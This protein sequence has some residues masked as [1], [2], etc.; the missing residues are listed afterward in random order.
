[1]R[2][3]DLPVIRVARPCREPWAEMAGDD[4]IRHC[5]RCDKDVHDLGAMTT[6]EILALFDRGT[7]WCGRLFR[8]ADGTVVTADCSEPP[9]RAAAAALGVGLALSTAA[10]GAICGTRHQ[11]YV[12]VAKPPVEAP[13]PPAAT[14][15]DEP[16]DDWM[17]GEIDPIE[18]ETMGVMISNEPPP[19][20]TPLQVEVVDPPDL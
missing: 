16:V 8:R 14:T 19:L 11:G 20:I 17:V 13:A 5:E 1:M 18:D 7:P 4:R 12:T 6:D 9:R 2:G 15:T 3:R 10:C